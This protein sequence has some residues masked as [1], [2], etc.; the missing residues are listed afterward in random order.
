MIVRN[1]L[2]TDVCNVWYEC[3]EF[4]YGASHSLFPGLTAYNL[5]MLNTIKTLKAS[6]ITSPK[7][8]LRNKDIFKGTILKSFRIQ[9]THSDFSSSCLC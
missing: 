5:N 6:S 9:N 1:N 2:L 3:G 8:M 4:Q 7:E